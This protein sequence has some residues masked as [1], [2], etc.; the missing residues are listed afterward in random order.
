[1][2]IAGSPDIFQEKMSDLMASLEFVRTYLDDVL[3]ITNS[4]FSDHLE[5]L[6]QVLKKLDEADLRVNVSKS[7]CCT[8]ELEYLGYVLTRDGIKPQNEKVSAI[9]A[10][11]PPTSVKTL[12]HFL[13]LVQYYRDLWEKRS[14]VLAPLTDL[15]GESGETKVT[16]RNGTK[17]IP[18]HWDQSHQK[19]FEAIKTTIARDV[20]LAY[21]DYSHVFEI[22]TDTSSRQLGAEEEG[23]LRF[24][25]ESYLQR[26]KSIQSQSWNYYL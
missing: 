26:N 8:S 2:G 12:R 14:D 21:P 6:E 22:Y 4:T 13:G 5:K 24:L 18:F 17:K 16:K 9:L 3:T 15:V 10:L 7:H 19:A 11:Q 25:V 23:P 20:V 1:M